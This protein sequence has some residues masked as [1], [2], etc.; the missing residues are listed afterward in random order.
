MTSE[1]RDTPYSLLVALDEDL[2]A[3]G[4]VYLDDGVSL[5]PNATRLVQVRTFCQCMSKYIC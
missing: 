5:E 2:N 3:A 1:T 4:S